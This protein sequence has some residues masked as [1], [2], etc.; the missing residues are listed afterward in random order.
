MSKTWILVANRGGARLFANDGAHKEMTLLRDITHDAVHLTASDLNSDRAGRTFDS[1]GAGRHGMGKGD[2]ATDHETERF[3]K[4]LATVLKDGRLKAEYSR[5]AL[6]AEPRF[7]GNLKSSLDD[8]TA[9]L[10][11][12][13]V[14]KDLAHVSDSDLPAIILEHI[15]ISNLG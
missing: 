9:K 13:T 6:F 14:T 12:E 7:L 10:V 4:E 5:L 1:H 11:T 2:S 15:R 8:Q 3:A